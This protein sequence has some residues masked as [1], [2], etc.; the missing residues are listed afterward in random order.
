MFFNNHLNHPI[1][2]IARVLKYPVLLIVAVGG[3]ILYNGFNP[4]SVDSTFEYFK[5]PTVARAERYLRDNYTSQQT[6]IDGLLVKNQQQYV[7]FQ[8]GLMIEEEAPF[9]MTFIYEKNFPI[10][11]GKILWRAVDDRFRL[12]LDEC[13]VYQ[14]DKKIFLKVNG[15]LVFEG[16]PLIDAYKKQLLMDKEFKAEEGHLK[17]AFSYDVQLSNQ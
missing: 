11:G 5:F 15:R 2:K 3:I 12:D 7:F 16:R 13:Y 8:K 17:K 9:N 1:M 14:K 4:V 10:D 6:V